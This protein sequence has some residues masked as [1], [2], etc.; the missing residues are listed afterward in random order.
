MSAGR[1]RVLRSF[2]HEGE[3][4]EVGRVVSLE[5]NE[6]IAALSAVGR[7]QPADQETAR[8]LQPTGPSWSPA[9]TTESRPQNYIR[10]GL[11][12]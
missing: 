6:I 10:D 9:T 5:D 1:F 8:R 11:Q 4:L 3:A 7:I 12:T 2:Y